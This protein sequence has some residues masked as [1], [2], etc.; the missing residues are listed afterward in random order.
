MFV[1]GSGAGTQECVC[2]ERPD[3]GGAVD[4]VKE[5]EAKT[6][7]DHGDNNRFPDFIDFPN[8]AAMP[9]S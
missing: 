9:I 2:D 3:P 5:H 4:Q 8:S 6:H 1:N 7:A